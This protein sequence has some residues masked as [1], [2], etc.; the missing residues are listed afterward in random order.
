MANFILHQ[1]LNINTFTVKI[2]HIENENI[3]STD[4]TNALSDTESL[5]YPSQIVEKLQDLYGVSKI[6]IF[7]EQNELLV[8]SEKFL[9]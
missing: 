6:E 4:I 1:T 3:N 9:P 8:N 5:E 7:N 2:Y